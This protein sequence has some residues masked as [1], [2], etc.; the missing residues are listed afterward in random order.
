MFSK[1]NDFDLFAEVLSVFQH[2]ATSLSIFG[3]K[4]PEI[5]MKG[6]NISRRTHLSSNIRTILG[7]M[8]IGCFEKNMKVV[9]SETHSGRGLQKT[10]TTIRNDHRK[11]VSTGSDVQSSPYLVQRFG[12]ENIISDWSVKIVHMLRYIENYGMSNRVSHCTHICH[13][14]GTGILIQC[15]SHVT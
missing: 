7:K 2:C 10:K 3:Y 14:S 5:S 11:A 8:K 12:R 15:Y 1:K 13:R 9:S 4:I 6:L